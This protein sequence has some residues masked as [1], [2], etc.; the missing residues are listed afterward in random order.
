MLEIDAHCHDESMDFALSKRHETHTSLRHMCL[1]LWNR[2]L[3]EILHV[4]NKK[5]QAAQCNFINDICNRNTDRLQ[6]AA[7][8]VE[9]AMM[10]EPE[11]QEAAAEPK[12][13]V[14]AAPGGAP[15]PRTVNFTDWPIKS[16]KQDFVI[17]VPNS[18]CV[19]LQ[20]R[21]TELVKSQRK[22]K[23]LQAGFNKGKFRANFD[24]MRHHLMLA[25]ASVPALV[26]KATAYFVPI[27]AS[28]FLIG[29][30]SI[31]VTAE[32]CVLN[33]PSETELRRLMLQ[34]TAKSMLET[35][36]MVKEAFAV[37]LACDKGNKK[38]MDHFIKFLCWWQIT[39]GVG[40]VE[41]VMIDSNVSGGTNVESG[42]AIVNSL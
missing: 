13:Q 2:P 21:C 37:Y 35:S 4:K 36:L 33:F 1:Q 5:M 3:D 25:L 23:S 10:D 6:R 9:V 42:L 11:V 19:V 40:R 32:K 29:H 28:A 39:D 15:R 31:K 7:A 12:V 20:S 16:Q 30:G 24:K 14:A 18:H 26:I 17:R 38:G 22:F 8:P 41:K 34:H 27:V